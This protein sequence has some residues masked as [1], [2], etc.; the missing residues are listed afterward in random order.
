MADGHFGRLRRRIPG[1]NDGRRRGIADDAVP[2]R[3]D[4]RIADAGGGTD[5]LFASITKAS[6]AWPHHTFGNVNWRLVGWLATGSVPGSL[7][8][9][10]LLRYLDPDTAAMGLFIKE[11]LVAAL[12]I[13]S[14]AILVYPL[15]TRGGSQA[16]E[17]TNV[18]SAAC[19]H[20][21]SGSSSAPS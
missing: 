6:A 5:L 21:R 2:D 10:A 11:A 7:A 12:L 8:M 14:V 20:W 3:K 16:V 13:S 17:P 4:R 15:V 9:L 19:R 18:P 1:R